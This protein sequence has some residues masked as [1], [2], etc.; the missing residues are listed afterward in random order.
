MVVVAPK[1]RKR[2]ERYRSGV[3][4]VDVVSRA[5]LEVHR[6]LYRGAEEWH[7]EV[8]DKPATLKELLRAEAKLEAAIASWMRDVGA[9]IMREVPGSSSPSS[10]ESMNWSR[11]H[12]RFVDETHEARQSIMKAGIEDAREELLQKTPRRAIAKQQGPAVLLDWSVDSPVVQKF[13]ADDSLT[14][15]K[16]L[17]KTTKG[18]IRN[19]LSRARADGLGIPETATRINAKVV[20]MSTWRARMIAQTETIRGYTQGALKTYKA[21]GV[22]QKEWL[23]GQAGADVQCQDLDGQVVD[24]EDSFEGGLDGPPAHVRCRCAVRAV[25]GEGLPTK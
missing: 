7:P 5:A 23:D 11:W 2:R 6:R 25:I 16:G 3:Q 12:T 9:W 10:V 15:A 4:S 14:L 24:L 22:E 13:L 17:T 21:A 20:G 1:R 19:V 18:N 8:R